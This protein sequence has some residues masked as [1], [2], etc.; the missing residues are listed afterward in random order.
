LEIRKGGE[1]TIPS[2]ADGVLW[3]KLYMQLER[4]SSL[5][6]FTLKPRNR[7]QRLQNIRKVLRGL[8]EKKSIPLSSLAMVEEELLEGKA[9]A[10]V[11]LLLRIRD[12]YKLQKYSSGGDGGDGNQHE[13]HM[14]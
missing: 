6:G 3:G 11:Q 5:P 4:C 1:V 8:S 14:R 9:D 13:E 2:F 10:V 12:V 7:A